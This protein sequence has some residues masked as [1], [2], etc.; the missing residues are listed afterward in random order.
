MQGRDASTAHTAT[1][2][3]VEEWAKPMGDKELV[4][5][6]ADWHPH[7]LAAVAAYAYLSVAGPATTSSK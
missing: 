1:D 5:V 3:T 4:Q 7:R 6:C 2:N